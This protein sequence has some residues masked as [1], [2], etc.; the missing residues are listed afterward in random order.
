VR[1]AIASY[2]VVAPIFSYV[3]LVRILATDSV[4]Q[5]LPFYVHYFLYFLP[6]LLFAAGVALFLRSKIAVVLYLCYFLISLASPL[7]MYPLYSDPYASNSFLHIY[8]KAATVP[9]VLAWLVAGAFAA[10]TWRLNSR[11]ALS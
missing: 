3:G 4:V 6:G 1:W 11:G 9:V 2:S 10:Y 7:I 8:R 5:H